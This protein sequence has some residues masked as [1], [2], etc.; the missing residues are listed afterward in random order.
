MGHFLL[1]SVVVAM[2]LAV[3]MC[4]KPQVSPGAVPADT[5]RIERDILALTSIRPPP[6]VLI[7]GYL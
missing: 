2:A 1:H 7:R 4:E 3:T 5:S 6:S